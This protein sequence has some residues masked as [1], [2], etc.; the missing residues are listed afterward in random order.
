MRYRDRFKNPQRKKMTRTEKLAW[1]RSAGG[2]LG[3][4]TADLRE[5]RYRARLAMPPRRLSEA[6]QNAIY[7][8]AV[9][10]TRRPSR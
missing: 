1:L 9:R 8:A 5:K 6:E 3:K 4:A 2:W 10:G 7:D